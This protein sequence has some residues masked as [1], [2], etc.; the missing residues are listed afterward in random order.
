MKIEILH[1]RLID[2]KNRVDAQ[3]N[4][5]IAAGRI[6]SIGTPPADWHAGKSINAQ[7][8]L[9]CPGLIDASVR[10]R[11]PGYEY[12]ATLESEM[13]AAVSAGVTSVVCPPDTDPVLDEPALVEMLKSRAKA[14]NQA[15]VYPLGALTV[16]L[17]GQDITEMGELTEA[18]C[19]GFSQAHTA[20]TDTRV[21]LRAM[22]YAATFDYPVWLSPQ[23]V[24][25]ARDGVAHD[26]EVATRLGL[27]PIPT[28]AETIATQQMIALAEHAGCRLHLC[29]MTSAAGLELVRA[30]KARGSKVSCDV[31]INHM[32]LIDVDIGYFDSHFALMP[33]LRSERDRAA[34]I[35]ALADGT[36]DLIV[37]DHTPVDDDAKELPFGEAEM[38]ATGVE[39]LLSLTWKW[40]KEQHIDLHTA[41]AKITAAPARLLG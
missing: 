29:R 19:V 30:A 17:K 24:H 22:Q 36:I 33:P 13:N 20:I 8:K 5:Y 15:H 37:S 32:H 7:G 9:V 39:L 16:G 25:L 41:L 3:K 28:L 4:I 21:L 40:A 31:S 10:L 18:G 34:I 14:M 38:G 27:P 6:I 35:R 2:P 26:G 23:D 11:E 1:G 12:K